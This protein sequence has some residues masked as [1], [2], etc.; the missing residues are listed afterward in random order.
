MRFRMYIEDDND[1]NFYFMDKNLLEN[2]LVHIM[3]CASLDD[4]DMTGERYNGLTLNY[5]IL[6]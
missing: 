2:I 4:D 1:T 6:H 5:R 3:N